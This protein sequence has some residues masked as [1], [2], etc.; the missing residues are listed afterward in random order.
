MAKPVQVIVV[1][2]LVADR[3]TDVVAQVNTAGAVTLSVGLVI[4]CVTVTLSFCVQ[5]LVA[6][7]VI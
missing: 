7:A 1:P 3:F 4:S 6:V 5:P 2:L